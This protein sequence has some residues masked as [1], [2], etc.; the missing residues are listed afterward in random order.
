MAAAHG[1]SA[2]SGSTPSDYLATRG[3]QL[4]TRIASRYRALQSS[5]ANKGTL[6]K[7]ARCVANF[8]QNPLPIYT[9]R[10]QMHMGA[11]HIST[12]SLPSASTSRTLAYLKSTPDIPPRLIAEF[13]FAHTIQRLRENSL[14]SKRMIQDRVRER[15][16][17]L[18]PPGP[19]ESEGE[20]IAIPSSIEGH[21]MMMR[22]VCTGVD[23][24]GKKIF[25]IVQ[26]NTGLGIE[27]HPNRMEDGQERY[28]TALEITD[29][30]E[31]KLCGASSHFFQ[32]LFDL[33]N[34]D[35]LTRV[36]RILTTCSQTDAEI[37]KLYEQILPQLG[38]II[39]PPS[40][41]RRLWSVG[42]RGGSC[43]T[44]CGL[45]LIRSQL[46]NA[47]YRAFKDQI[48]LDI[49]F[50]S[51]EDITRGDSSKS[52]KRLTR[53]LLLR[54]EQI[55]AKSASVA[56]GEFQSVQ[57]EVEAMLENAPSPLPHLPALTAVSERQ[58][59]TSS[60]T[61]GQPHHVE[62]VPLSGRNSPI[63]HLQEALK[64]VQR[65]HFDRSSLEKSLELIQAAQTQAAENPPIHLEDVQLFSDLI[66]TIKSLYEK[67]EK[68]LELSL[69][70]TY[71]LTALVTSMQSMYSAYE[72]RL[73]SA[74]REELSHLDRSLHE[75][76]KKMKLTSYPFTRRP[77]FCHMLPLIL[78]RQQHWDRQRTTPV[79]SKEN[80][81]MRDN[82]EI[83]RLRRSLPENRNQ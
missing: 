9:L 19:G 50:K 65:G 13:E 37:K 11:E 5:E 44:S 33:G 7:I 78:Q 14:Y 35:V 47:Q 27:Y 16:Q 30:P 81:R 67:K 77:P 36:R 12:G 49:L 15:V 60:Q 10:W 59:V 31:E 62:R 70:Q 3:Q 79:P 57:R 53:E 28:Q 71:I 6:A 63:S 25:K 43:T 8:F 76:F 66:H 56:S 40:E 17:E 75:T 80:R 32:D 34:Q 29:V 45:S 21:A 48:R 20:S 2:L 72:S 23:T 18:K 73:S 58:H 4:A 51:I 52:R 41:D 64:A 38:G 69:Q 55:I 1:Q 82:A 24:S 83:E 68:A 26:H 42:Q 22:I 61:R 54:L 39:S 46:P 74:A